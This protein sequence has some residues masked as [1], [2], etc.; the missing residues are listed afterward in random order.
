MKSNHL[1]ENP[2]YIAA[3][4]QA[5]RLERELARLDAEIVDHDASALSAVQFFG[6]RRLHAGIAV[7]DG[8]VSNQSEKRAKLCTARAAV[9]D[10]IT[11]AHREIDNT[12][13]QAS[14]D[15][16][17]G[18]ASAV[19]AALDG[20]VAALDGVVAAGAA[21]QAIRDAGEKL[22]YDVDTT[23]LPLSA[24][25]SYTEYANGWLPDLRKSADALRDSLDPSLDVGRLHVRA[26]I[27]M[28]THA[29]KVGQLGSIPTRQ[30]RELIRDSRAEEVDVRERLRVL[31]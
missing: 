24:D 17:K 4:E 25:K 1:N 30:A 10:A 15:Y 29:L 23:S 21:F 3:R 8:D 28:P 6:D 26:L 22:G 5:T 2:A 20:L 16:F 14:R 11:P 19:L 27:D 31:T 18:H 9:A 7:L 12:I 13:R